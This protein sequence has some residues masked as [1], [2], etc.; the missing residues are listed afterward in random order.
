MKHIEKNKIE[1]AEHTEQVNEDAIK[2]LKDKTPNI[3][4]H[5]EGSQVIHITHEGE[6][7]IHHNSSEV[8]KLRAEIK[9]YKKLLEEAENCVEENN[10]KF[11]ALLNAKDDEIQV[12]KDTLLL[13]RPGSQ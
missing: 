10:K 11:V 7:D 13:L 3:V 12:L 9:L 1:G 4:Q 8:K 6:G 2:A 5:G